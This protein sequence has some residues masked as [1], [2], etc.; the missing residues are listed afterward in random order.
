M[1][2]AGGRAARMIDL[3]RDLVAQLQRARLDHAVMQ[4]Q[5]VQLLLRVLDGEARALGA[6][7]EPTAV[8]DLAAGFGIERRLVDDDDAAL[9]LLQRPSPRAPS[10]TSAT[11]SPDAAS[12]S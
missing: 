12:V 8:A 11:I 10:L 5:A 3:E 2:R 1:M 4:E 9:A 6:D 7:H